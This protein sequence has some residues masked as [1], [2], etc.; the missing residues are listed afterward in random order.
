MV[1]E[2]ACARMAAMDRMETVPAQWGRRRGAARKEEA[3]RRLRGPGQRAP[4]GITSPS[5]AAKHVRPRSPPPRRNR[6]AMGAVLSK[7]GLAGR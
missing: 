4:G 3:A 1:V 2:R 7:E 5:T 6:L